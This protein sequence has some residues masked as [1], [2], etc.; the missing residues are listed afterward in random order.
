MQ[1]PQLGMG[2]RAP[3]HLAIAASGI[4]CAVTRRPQPMLR[5]SACAY[6]QGM[7]VGPDPCVLCAA[8]IHRPGRRAQRTRRSSLIFDQDWPDD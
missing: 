1:H 5:C 3:T 7:L 4:V 2:H 6:F 8:P